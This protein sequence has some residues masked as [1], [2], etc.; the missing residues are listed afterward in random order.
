MNPRPTSASRRVASARPSRVRAFTLVE[1]M[2]VVGLA[3]L[4]MAVGIP[5]FVNARHKAPLRQTVQNLT[6]VFSRARA[7]AI[8]TGRAVELRIRPIDGVFELG[9]V[10][11]GANVPGA[12]AITLP[13][14]VGI[15]LLDVNLQPMKDAEEA[16]VRFHANGTC[17]LFALVLRSVEN[18]MCMVTL[19]LT[20]GLARVEHDPQNFMKAAR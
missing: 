8:M 9:S 11:G 19:E 3:A 2:L 4:A 12:M 13:A 20:T 18:E 16:V 10:T 14:E 6:E 1:L 5:A 15:E 17:D 7:Q